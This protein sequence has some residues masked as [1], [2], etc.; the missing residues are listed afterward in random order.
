MSFAITQRDNFSIDV[1][2]EYRDDCDCA[3]DAL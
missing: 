3:K 1:E 2:N